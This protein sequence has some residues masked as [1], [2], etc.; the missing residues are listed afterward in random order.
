[1]ELRNLFAIKSGVPFNRWAALAGLVLSGPAAADDGR[2]QGGWDTDGTPLYVC[3]ARHG[4]GSHQPGK[5]RGDKCFYGWGG[6]EYAT[7]DYR[8]VTPP[9]GYHAIWYTYIPGDHPNPRYRGDEAYW[10]AGIDSDGTRLF[11]CAAFVPR[12]NANS[13]DRTC[14]PGATRQ[15]AQI[16]PGKMREVP[17]MDPGDEGGTNCHISWGG[18]EYIIPGKTSEYILELVFSK[19]YECGQYPGY[20]S[21]CVPP[22][23]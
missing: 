13:S 10:P 23:N 5:L 20:E 17:G 3:I 12:C 6:R 4:D 18:K 7:S 14:P 15:G 16:A 11:V 2:I 1:M 8:V 9:K 22:W 21:V 19:K